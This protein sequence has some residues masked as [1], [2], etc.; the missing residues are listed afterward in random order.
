MVAHEAPNSFSNSSLSD[1]VRPLQK[2]QPGR[3]S[4]LP[5]C[6]CNNFNAVL[7]LFVQRNI[8]W[9]SNVSP[10]TPRP[11]HRNIVSL[12][13]MNLEDVAHISLCS[14]KTYRKPPK[15]DQSEAVFKQ[16]S[17][18][19][20]DLYL[21]SLKIV[22]NLW[23]D[24][25]RPKFATGPYLFT[26][27]VYQKLFLFLTLDFDVGGTSKKFRTAPTVKKGQL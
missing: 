9:R 12:T 10:V 11:I 13:W 2:S 23:Q 5:S 4:T 25:K 26:G 17:V 18:S 24:M 21:T 1:S 14:L 8:M 15:T 27:S 16:S 6:Y 7:G 3:R 19:D 22:L 20:P